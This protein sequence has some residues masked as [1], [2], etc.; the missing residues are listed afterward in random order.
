LQS[1]LAFTPYAKPLLPAL[2]MYAIVMVE[3]PT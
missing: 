2:W 1:H 3:T